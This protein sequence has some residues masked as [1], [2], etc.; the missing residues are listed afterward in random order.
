MARKPS[1]KPWKCKHGCKVTQ[2]PCVHL[3]KLLSNR[4]GNR[5]VK[6]MY[7]PDI[8]RTALS[9]HHTQSYTELLYS[10][11]HELQNFRNFLRKYALQEYQLNL[12][13]DRFVYNK[14]FKEI[15][16][17]QQ[18]ASLTACFRVFSKTVE[19]LVERG[20]TLSD[21]KRVVKAL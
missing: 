18:W 9:P 10:N 19:L 21:L 7:R 4:T 2:T 8:E 3:E 20:I 16:A 12:L 13:I 5:Q 1:K 11:P 15:Y 14:T 6:L 17:E